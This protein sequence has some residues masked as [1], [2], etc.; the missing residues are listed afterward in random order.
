M[1]SKHGCSAAIAVW[2]DAGRE[3][4]FASVGRAAPDAA[5]AGNRWI[6]PDLAERR[7]QRP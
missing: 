1:A 6:F 2:T 3:V 4:A 7:L 5:D